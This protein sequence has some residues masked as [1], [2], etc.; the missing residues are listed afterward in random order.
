M[1]DL[2]EILGIK[3]KK[4][5]PAAKTASLDA[6][7]FGETAAKAPASVRTA[8]LDAQGID[9]AEVKR[10]AAAGEQIVQSGIRSGSPIER[11]GALGV[12]GITGAAEGIG[13][14]VGL[15][16]DIVTAPVRGVIAAAKTEGGYGTKVKASLDAILGLPA[17]RTATAAADD[18]RKTARG[19]MGLNGVEIG[20]T[21]DVVRFGADVLMPGPEVVGAVRQIKGAKVA[22]NLVDDAVPPS[23]VSAAV[24]EPPVAPGMVRLY[25]GGVEDSGGGKRWVTPDRKYAQGYADKVGGGGGVVKYV[26]LPDGHALLT[27]SFDDSGTDVVAPYNAFEAP[28]EIARNLRTI[29]AIAEPEAVASGGKWDATPPDAAPP[30]T[31]AQVWDEYQQARKETEEATRAAQSIIDE[32]EGRLENAV[33]PGE[34]GSPGFMR[35]HSV[36][37]GRI[38]FEK[39]SPRAQ[40]RIL[41]DAYAK[42]D[43]AIKGAVEKEAALAK[44]LDEVA[45]REAGVEANPRPMSEGGGNASDAMPPGRGEVVNFPP[46]KGPTD[47]PPSSGGIKP[48]SGDKDKYA[49][50][51]AQNME[52]MTVSEQADTL[53]RDTAEKIGAES[54]ERGDSVRHADIKA[55]A[56]EDG[57]LLQSAIGKDETEKFAAT[58]HRTATHL[59]NMAEGGV[60]TRELV[61][62]FKNV[63][64]A[65]THIGRLLNSFAIQTES[66]AGVAMREMI[67]RLDEM[68][69]TTDEILKDLEGVD[70]NDPAQAQKAFETKIKPKLGEIIDAYRYANLLSSPKT[71]IVNITS[72]WLQAGILRP[73]DRA[74]AAMWDGLYS[75]YKGKEREHFASLPA[76][77]KGQ[78]SALQKA[79][80]AAVAA[81]KGKA[82]MTHL[83]LQRSAAASKLPPGLKHVSRLLEAQDKFF[84]TIIE[85]GE[86]AALADGAKKAGKAI[87]EVEI[88]SKAQATA[89][90]LTFR[91]PL[92]P[93]N[94][95]K[96]GHILSIVD[97]FSGG[98][99]AFLDTKVGGSRP[100]RWVVPFIQTPMNILKQGLEHTPMGFATMW[101]ATDKA[102]QAAKAT[103]GSLVFMGAGML[104]MQDR[105]TWSVPKG[106][107]DKAAFLATRQPYSVLIG[108]HWVAYQRLGPIAFPIALAAAM[109]HYSEDA[110]T[111]D[112]FDADAIAKG[113]A[114]MIPFFGRQSY[115]EQIGNIMDA[116][117]SE[118]PAS[119][120]VIANF[121]KQM[122]T[123]VSL[124]RWIT[125]IVDPVYRKAG[126]RLGRNGLRNI[127][128]QLQKD[129]PG[130]SEG[131]PAAKG[132]DG[133]PAQRKMPEV[134]AV[135][136]VEV[137]PAGTPEQENRW[138]R[139]KREAQRRER[140][141]QRKEE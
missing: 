89:K 18:L 120:D 128:Q 55:K 104:S 50:P 53:L 27:K 37:S 21:G 59:A 83:D 16:S 66:G 108:G 124:Q 7:L 68:G 129:I 25:S 41:K 125:T 91:K 31:T 140:E 49:R 93:S 6:I 10:R 102:A 40:E 8:A 114:A 47:V 86:Y 111:A 13:G 85:G 43:E 109:K 26:D 75:K 137:R 71:H 82:P 57:E 33:S 38:G 110:P 35:A 100:F 80:E 46:P 42:R 117:T 2:D 44:E 36:E 15:T 122:I 84:M 105:T 65:K 95:T 23:L 138:Q 4:G 118:D 67:E 135:S 54:F 51:S 24:D 96:Q 56:A 72:N 115:M 28:E 87:N 73:A 134:N 48:P 22:D 76:Y 5:T 9:S 63:S 62:T 132:P 19:A 94:E 119:A 3:P 116:V 92:D 141:R 101:G 81:F 112:G 106:E 136:P 34:A 17:T 29:K 133:K 1:P 32:A 74:M 30:R 126:K 121:P 39:L 69:K 58:I 60:A 90:E 45:A 14:L 130:L 107:K 139:R 79:W 88:A 113:V 64:T 103:T 99:Q 12:E 131:V 61:E 98:M 123:A 77:F 11:L 78:A 70:F 52:R 20:P 97:R 127:M